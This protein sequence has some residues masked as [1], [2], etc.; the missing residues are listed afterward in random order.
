[1]RL[2][3]SSNVD[4]DYEEEV[5]VQQRL[6]AHDDLWSPSHQSIRS[7][8]YRGK[9][10]SQ[11]SWSNYVAVTSQSSVQ[12]ASGCW[13]WR[14]ELPAVAPQWRKQWFALVSGYL[15]FKKQKRGRT[16]RSIPVVEISL[17]YKDNVEVANPPG[18]VRN[19]GLVCE[20]HPSKTDGSV[21]RLLICAE[22]IG[23]RNELLHVLRTEVRQAEAAIEG[24]KALSGDPVF[25]TRVGTHEK[26]T[27]SLLSHMKTLLKRHHATRGDAEE[28]A[29][30][31]VTRVTTGT[32]F[33]TQWQSL[34]NFIKHRSLQNVHYLEAQLT[35][36]SRL[37]HGGNTLALNWLQSFMTREVIQEGLQLSLEHP[38]A[39]L[40]RAAFADLAITVYLEPA[41][42]SPDA[43][44]QKHRAFL[45]QLKTVVDEHLRRPHQKKA[46]QKGEQS[47]FNEHKFTASVLRMCNKLIAAGSYSSSELTLLLPPLVKVLSRY[48]PQTATKVEVSNDLLGIL[49]PRQQATPQ[50][51][52]KRDRMDATIPE[53]QM[54]VMDTKLEACN[55]L[56]RLFSDTKT[57]RL[58]SALFTPIHKDGLDQLTTALLSTVLHTGHDPL[59]LTAVRLLFRNL[60]TCV[61]DDCETDAE[62]HTRLAVILQRRLDEGKPEVL[63]ALF[64]LID[65]A[66]SDA[67]LETATSTTLAVMKTLMRMIYLSKEIPH[68]MLKVQTDLDSLGLAP[69]VAVMIEAKDERVVYHSLTLMIALMHGG[70]AVV[71]ESLSHYFLSR[72]DEALFVTLR[73]R[74]SSAVYLIKECGAQGAERLQLLRNCNLHHIREVL[75]VLQLFA[76]GHNIDMQDYLRHQADNVVS[77]NLVKESFSFLCVILTMDRHSSFTQSIVVQAFDSL[78]EYCQGPCKGNQIQLIKG[79]ITSQVT[80]ALSRQF[81]GLSKLQVNEVR[82]AAVLCLHAV[83]EGVTNTDQLSISV[84]RTLDTGVLRKVLEEAW[85]D[86]QNET[87]L[88]VAFNVFILLKMLKMANTLADTRG[89][90]FLD[91]MTGGI[92]ICRDGRLERVFFRI[93]SISANLSSE[94]KEDLLRSVDRSTPTARISDFYYRA[95]GLIFEIEYFQR[96]FHEPKSTRVAEI[97]RTVQQLLHNW[98]STWHTLMI[99]TAFLA[100]ILL[101]IFAVY[102]PAEEGDVPRDWTMQIPGLLQLLLQC[103]AVVQM[104]LAT[105]LLSDFLL[106]KA[107]L[108][109]FTDNK[110]SR[111]EAMRKANQRL[112]NSQMTAWW[113]SAESTD[114]GAQPPT[115]LRSDKVAASAASASGSASGKDQAAEEES[116]LHGTDISR[117]LSDESYSVMAMMWRFRTDVRLVFYGA[118]L[119]TAIM[120]LGDSPVYLSFHLLAV[121]GRSPVLV[122]VITAV[123]RHSR[124]LLLTAL[125]GSV[126]VYLFTVM[127]FTLF[128]DKFGPEVE[129][130]DAAACDS[131]RGCFRYLLVNAVRAGGGV[132]DLIQDHSWYDR[133]YMLFG[134][135]S[136]FL[137]FVIIIVILLNIIS[138]VI[139]D[140]FARLREERQV[141]EDD[142]RSRCFICGIESTQFDRQGEGFDSHIK[143]DHN[144][145][146]YIYFLHHLLKKDVAELTGPESYVYKM[147]QKQDLGY[148]PLNKAIVLEGKREE[149][150][151]LLYI[152]NDD[153]QLQDKLVDI[154]TKLSQVH[155]VWRKSHQEQKQDV[156]QLCESAVRTVVDAHKATEDVPDEA[157]PPSSPPPSNRP[158]PLSGGHKIALNSST[159]SPGRGTPRGLLTPLTAS[160]ANSSMKRA[161]NLESSARRLSFASP[162][163]PLLSPRT[164]LKSPK[165]PSGAKSGTWG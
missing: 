2:I 159:K 163:T 84:Q 6:G 67:L 145:W 39:P 155:Q 57:Y 22:C 152:A 101:L 85:S 17:V 72:N 96:I 79:N 61:G 157:Q 99:G 19:F 134:L 26:K 75:R 147:I 51:Y 66:L 116:D 33:D 71:Q 131:L 35:L 41:K 49:Q 108:V 128:R 28:E 5:A 137:F 48:A 90:A 158:P 24:T 81:D 80:G 146:Y 100:N 114:P 154:E 115:N 118:C 70:N 53:L 107:P 10:P 156:S 92:E 12:A 83:L 121:T 30:D 88:E 97:L 95:E 20:F 42:N 37:C 40:I 89:F 113:D 58:M 144:L 126:V 125:L 132:G 56:M 13:V 50:A 36:W 16:L 151:R 133:P 69:L 127:A 18:A 142:I 162:R 68:R 104:A 7:F 21:R 93:P 138:G 165:T 65:G 140:T 164:P 91:T 123:T 109:A 87:S 44:S 124:A 143:N 62:S 34:S 9:K 153:R 141:V 78:T 86:K 129:G 45:S 60:S 112:S 23:E 119:L 106:S 74:I 29:G 111:M 31:K 46:G 4:S 77:Y 54:R 38:L 122:N 15:T 52:Y 47:L 136:D 149:E 98:N 135:L 59:Y 27:A 64:R 139:I 73:N 8:L 25:A 11:G 105:C 63:L 14:C 76:E 32:R 3:R 120:A 117:V 82:S 94:T 110:K 102:G 43:Y 55:V 161:P 103:I 160:R 130:D 150:D 148:F 1:M